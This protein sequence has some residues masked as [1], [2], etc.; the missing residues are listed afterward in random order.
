[1]P[2]SSRFSPR[3][4]AAIESW[5]MR[6]QGKV[7]LI[8]GAANGV[9][10]QMMGIGG[11]AAGMFAREGAAVVVADVADDAG[12]QTAAGIR[13]DP[14]IRVVRPTP[15]APTVGNHDLG[16]QTTVAARGGTFGRSSAGFHHGFLCFH[17]DNIHAPTKFGGKCHR[18]HDV[19]D[20]AGSVARSHRSPQGRAEL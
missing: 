6:L 19:A 10:G 3:Q 11:A 13:A 8:T 20:G 16:N 1:M 15:R 9:E 4:R 12:E 7:A 5:P 17:A 14:R 2:L 18:S